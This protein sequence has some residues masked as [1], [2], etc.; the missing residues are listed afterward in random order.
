[1]A[2]IIDILSPNMDQC[3]YF[4]CNKAITFVDIVNPAVPPPEEGGKQLP[5]LYNSGN[6]A[7]FTKGDSFSILTAGF[8]IPEAFTLFRDENDTTHPNP[9]LPLLIESAVGTNL[10]VMDTL[11]RFIG[12]E[13]QSVLMLPMENYEHAIDVFVDVPNQLLF[14]GGGAKLNE[15]FVLCG[16]QIVFGRI[17]MAGIPDNFDGRKFII[18]PFIKILHNFELVSY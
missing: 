1:M 10:Y 9:I 7:K 15:D 17:S 5:I 8:V 12:T 13:S 14:N 2:E 18:V 11:P 6:F 16:G 3:P 4:T